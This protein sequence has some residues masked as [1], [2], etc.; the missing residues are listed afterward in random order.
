MDSRGFGANFKLWLLRS[1]AAEEGLDTEV[2][3]QAEEAMQFLKETREWGILMDA[4]ETFLLVEWN[5]G[6]FMRVEALAREMSVIG[7]AHHLEDRDQARDY[8]LGRS[9]LSQGDLPQARQRLIAA[10]PMLNKRADVNIIIDLLDTFAVYLA[11]RGETNL[12]AR[13]FGAQ[14]ERY[15]LFHLGFAVRQRREHDEALAALRQAMGEAAFSAAFAEGQAAPLEQAVQWV[16]ENI[17]A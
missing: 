1:T 14:E 17:G 8:W 15:R 9:A 2:Y 12:A 6:N 7:H 3:N 13:L 16:F 4:Y 10:S 11:A 5:Q